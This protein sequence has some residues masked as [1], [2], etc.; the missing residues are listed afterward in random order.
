MNYTVLVVDDDP[1]IH[2]LTRMSL[3][4]MEYQN[5]PIHLES[6]NS[7]AEAIAYM[8]AHPDTP[9]ILLDV[10]MENDR[11]GL[12]VVHAIRGQQGNELVRILLRTGQ[13]G[14]APEKEVIDAYDIDGY[15]PKA[16]LTQRRLYTAVRTAIKH[17]SEL[18]EL[19][20]HRDTL[21]YINAS[22]LNLHGAS[23]IEECLQRLIQIAAASVP[24]DLALLYFARQRVG[25][26]EEYFYYQGREGKAEFSEKAQMLLDELL[27][28]KGSITE[29]TSFGSGYLTPLILAE[30]KGLGF[31]YV[32]RQI[33]EAL[34]G[35]ILPILAAHAAIAL[36]LY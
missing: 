21:S 8:Q 29:P 25:K 34:V 5:T 18:K 11:S 28:Q 15:L 27:A 35:Q 17:H 30:G 31:L 2:E 36:V 9:V 16:E 32:E 6:V 20:Y 23:H 24:S 10:V 1:D 3:K 7:G 19:Q 14:I 12:D 33:N 4:R 22:I 26:P 13:P